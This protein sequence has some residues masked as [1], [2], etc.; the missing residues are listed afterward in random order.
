[1]TVPPAPT[2]SSAVTPLLTNNDYMHSSYARIGEP[3]N[4]HGRGQS[5]WKKLYDAEPPIAGRGLILGGTPWLASHLAARLDKVYVVDVSAPMV[6]M[7][8]DGA[9]ARMSRLVPLQGDWRVLPPMCDGLDVVAGD[10]S[11]SFMPY[12]CGWNDLCAHLSARMRPGARLMMRVCS[13]PHDHRTEEPAE[14]VRRF[15][16]KDSINYTELR[17]TLLFAEWDRST[18]SIDTESALVSFERHQRHFQPL[19]EKFPLPPDNDLLTL[20]KYRGSGAVYYAP[21]LDEILALLA[22]SFY[23]TS[24]AF[25][26]YGMANYFPLITAY[27]P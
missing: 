2:P 18:Y 9:S 16:R 15:S 4:L 22:R 11:F 8:T 23:V 5:W 21:P 17:A 6:S 24:V 25:G 14:I 1:M 26:P 19:F 7:L 20:A 3:L 13:V 12:P 10:N 27:R